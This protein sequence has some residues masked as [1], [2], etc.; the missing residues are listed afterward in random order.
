M[1][2]ATTQTGAELSELAT[3]RPVLVFKKKALFGGFGGFMVW[4][5]NFDYFERPIWVLPLQR[6]SPMT[7]WVIRHHLEP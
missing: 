6:L 3:N 5:E 7:N 4:G 1:A 2:S